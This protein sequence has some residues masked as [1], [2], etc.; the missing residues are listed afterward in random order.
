MDPIPSTLGGHVVNDTPTHQPLDESH[1]TSTNGRSGG[2]IK[3]D[4]MWPKR[5]SGRNYN[6]KAGVGTIFGTKTSVFWDMTLG[7][8]TVE[9]AKFMK[10]TM[11]QSM[12]VKE[13]G[14]AVPKPWNQT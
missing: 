10:R 3:Y 2:A 4:M 9:C 6:S 14:F 8:K 7:I 1:A 13:T 5:G 11:H 12:S